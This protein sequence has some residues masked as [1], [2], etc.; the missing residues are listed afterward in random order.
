MFAP[1]GNLENKFEPQMGFE[2]MTFHDLVG[3]SNHWAT[4]LSRTS[5]GEMSVFD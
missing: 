3:C 5:K 2:P 4:A 1:N